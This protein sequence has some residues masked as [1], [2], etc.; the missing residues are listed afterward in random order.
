MIRFIHIILIVICLSLLGIS[1]APAVYFDLAENHIDITTGFNGSHIVVIGAAPPKGEIAIEVVGPH[2]EATVRLKNQVA[3]AWVNT[4]SLTY[5]DI[6][7]FYDYALSN[8]DPEFE[9]TAK[10]GE[11]Y[12][13]LR[14]EDNDLS[15]DELKSFN[16]ALLRNKRALRLY[17]K[18]AK[19][20]EF[21]HEGAM[22]RADFYIPSNVPIG[23]Y[24][25]KVH[26]VDNGAITSTEIRSVKVAQVGTSAW[27]AAFARKQSL[28]YGLCCVALALFAGWFSNRVR[29]RA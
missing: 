5:K 3:G 22:F 25:V 18:E 4:Q 2:R 20:I 15:A 1:Q 12:L 8:L 7:V 26:L 10:I 13:A 9:K 16:K 23:D 28:I 24:L 19:P 27:L 6:P 21:L 14:T 29:R 11:E 17:P